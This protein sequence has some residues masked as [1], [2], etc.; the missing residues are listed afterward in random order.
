[1]AVSGYGREHRR[2]KDPVADENAYELAPVL[3]HKLH[4][5]AVRAVVL[6]AAKQALHVRLRNI[7]YVY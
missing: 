7:S 5:H 1:M 2:A 3:W 6:A 4:R